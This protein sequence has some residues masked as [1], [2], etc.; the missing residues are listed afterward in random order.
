MSSILEGGESGEGLSEDD[1]YIDSDVSL[2]ENEI[3]EGKIIKVDGDWSPMTINVPAPKDAS[4]HPFGEGVSQMAGGGRFIFMISSGPEQTRAF[5]NGGPKLLTPR[6]SEG[7]NAEDKQK[8][9]AEAMMADKAL[10]AITDSSIILRL[11][12]RA[13]GTEG[14][15]RH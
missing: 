15:L 7:E 14:L 4:T 10:G 13:F 1:L 2:D 8:N 5:L 9:D 12:V 11:P 3:I 6:D